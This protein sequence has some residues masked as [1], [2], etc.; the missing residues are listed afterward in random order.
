MT[1][2]MKIASVTM[3][4][5]LLVSITVARSCGGFRAAQLPIA[6]VSVQKILSQ[7][8]DAKAA[9]AQLEKLRESK[10]AEIDKERQALDSMRRRI[11]DPAVSADE[12]QKLV[13]DALQQETKLQ[14]ATRQ[15][16]A[17]IQEL[18]G[19]LQG[20]M[21]DE[22]ARVVSAL[23]GEKGFQYVFN[24]DGAMLVAPATTDLTKEVLARLNAFAAARPKGQ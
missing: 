22:L 2:T 16:Q 14:E 17:D 6:S 4:V 10:T 8:D 12:R 5:P 20:Q 24:Q 18:Q 1:F 3:A 9:T 15:A 23:A 11:A 13:T 7:A 19:R 21:R